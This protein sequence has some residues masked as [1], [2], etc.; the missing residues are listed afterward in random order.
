MPGLSL[1]QLGGAL[2][3]VT[4]TAAAS[5]ASISQQ[6][7][8][9]HARRNRIRDRRGDCR[10]REGAEVSP[11]SG[12]GVVNRPCLAAITLDPMGGGVAAVSR[13][14]WRV[15]QHRWAEDARLVT[16][17]NDQAAL[18]TL[19]SSTA[20]RVRF[21]AHIATLQV[22][23]DV[24]LQGHALLGRARADLRSAADA[25]AVCSVHSR[26][27]SVA[28]AAAHH[29][30]RAPGQPFGSPTPPSRRGASPRCT[31]HWPDRAVSAGAVTGAT[32]ASLRHG[33]ERARY[34]RA[35]RARRRADVIGRALQGSRRAAR[36]VAGG[37][38][39]R[40]GRPAGARRRRR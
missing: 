38:E 27:R 32:R 20:T 1:L 6:Q 19:D 4:A 18:Q 3:E 29:H 13:L 5:M 37:V 33:C 21:G 17:L 15:F 12:G 22:F 23:A 26:H 2:A 9:P 28:A 36:R 40:A 25:P 11:A 10:R 35:R 14:L 16:L 39:D 30:G 7:R 24:G 8:R 31:R 34:R